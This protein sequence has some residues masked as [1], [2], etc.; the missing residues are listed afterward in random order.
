MT[1]KTPLKPAQNPGNTPVE[2]WS[3][4]QLRAYHSRPGAKDELARRVV[5]VIREAEGR[6]VANAPGRTRS[7]VE[8]LND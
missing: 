3:L 7:A 5:A 8:W 6:I 1:T 2:T 4:D